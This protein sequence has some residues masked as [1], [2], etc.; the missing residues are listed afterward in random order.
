M[1]TVN[2]ILLGN[3]RPAVEFG[4]SAFPMTGERTCGD[5]HV[6]KIAGACAT[7]AAVDGGGHGEAAAHAAKIAV[8][9]IENNALTDVSS[10]VQLCHVALRRTRGAVMSLA[11]FDGRRN[12]MTWVGVGNVE[13]VL[14]RAQHGVRLR[15]EALFLRGGM[16]GCSLPVLRPASLP[17]SR[18][19]VLILTTDGISTPFDGRLKLSDPPQRMAEQICSLYGKATDDGLALV[20]Q[21]LGCEP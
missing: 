6:V 8:T 11:A 14:F 7:V 9:T 4:V 3:L 2:D 15:R 20:I 5:L 12:T 10:L 1:A 13:G 18:G 19:D 21:Y 17:V 16:I